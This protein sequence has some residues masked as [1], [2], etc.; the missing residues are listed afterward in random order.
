MKVYN[1]LDEIEFNRN[2]VVT[3]GSF[4]G[5]H[6]GHKAILDD[7]KVRAKNSNSRSVVVTFN[8]QLRDVVGRGPVQHL[9]T[10]DERLKH[11]EQSGIDET[12]IINFT[13]E[14]SQQSAR[15]FY[16]QYLVQKIGVRDVVIGHDHMFGKNREGSIDVLTK[17]GDELGFN[18][19]MIPE[20]R[21]K[22]NVV[23]SSLIRECLTQGRV[24]EANEYLGRH[25]T[26]QAHVVHGDGRGT[27][28]GFP[29]ANV[30][31]DQTKKLTP[32]FGVYF[33]HVSHANTEYF[34][35]M[36]IGVRP[37]F[38]L[39][40][41][42]FIEVHLLDFSGNL[43][44]ETLSVSFLKRLRAEKKFHSSDELVAQLHQDRTGVQK[45][46]SQLTVK[47]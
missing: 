22:E 37:T 7:V 35:M 3:I 10:L 43:Y 45:L 42:Q 46:V 16:E 19:V 44:G 1:G 27:T 4:D 47:S 41:Q 14:F 29:T 15:T 23:C 12:L 40:G 8:P 34:G 36:N 24:E 26:I 18:V 39:N 6:V 33:V 38:G 9:C 25:Y 28:I 32:L 13:H 17:I 20:V 30:V 2:S 5:V 31:F 21:V 11:L